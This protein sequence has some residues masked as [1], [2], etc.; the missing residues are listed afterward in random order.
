M[1]HEGPET[2]GV[3]VLHTALSSYAEAVSMRPVPDPT[4]GTGST[5]FPIPDAMR[6]V[7]IDDLLR[8]ASSGADRTE[9]FNEVLARRRSIR[10]YGSLAAAD[11]AVLLDQVFA[12][13]G[14]AQ[15]D[16]GAVRRF[17]PIPSAG[18]RHPLVPLALVESVA[19]LEAGL[20]RFDLDGRRILLIEKNA[21]LLD[22][23]WRKVTAAGQ[24][25]KRPPAVVVLGARFDATLARYPAGAALVWRDAGVALGTLHLSATAIGLGSC[26]LGTAGVLNDRLLAASG[27]SGNLVGDVGALAV[28]GPVDSQISGHPT[29]AT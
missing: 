3:P 12:P 16:D 22:G 28:G 18:A 25:T 5:C 13:R 26:I 11:L 15:A 6:T 21:R 20:W 27:L 14:F 7:P 9:P 10:E 1:T 29:G 4:I 23:A 8:I 2:S 17:R 24:F 19:G